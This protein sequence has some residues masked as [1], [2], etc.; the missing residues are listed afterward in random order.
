MRKTKKK[1]RFAFPLLALVVCLVIVTG[2]TFSLFTSETGVNIAV[3]SGTVKMTAIIDNNSLVLSSKGVDRTGENKLTFENGGTAKFETDEE[4]N[5]PVLVLTN[6]T[7]GDSVAF[8][9]D[10]KNES[11]VDLQYRVTWFVESTNPTVVGEETFD[12]YD[13]LVAE[14]DGVAISNGT[15]QWTL[16]QPTSE[17]GKMEKTIKVSITF[18]MG[19][20]AQLEEYKS[21]MGQTVNIGFTVEAVQANGTAEYSETAYV[22]NAT[23]LQDAINA[24]ATKIILNKDIDLANTLEIPASASTFSLKDEFDGVVLDLNGHTI[25]APVDPERA[26]GGHYYAIINYGNLL[27]TGNGTINSRGVENHGSMTIENGTYNNIDTDGGQAIRNIDGFVHIING[28]FSAQ[29]GYAVLT[30]S[31]ADV[32]CG[33]MIIDNATING[34]IYFIGEELVINNADVVNTKSGRHTVYAWGSK[35]TIEDGKF[36]NENTSNATIKADDCIVEINGGKYTIADGNATVGWTSFLIDNLGASHVTVNGGDFNGHIRTNGMT[37]NEGNFNDGY[38]SGYTV[39][40]EVVINGGSFTGANSVNFAKNYLSDDSSL[41]EGE[42]GTFVTIPVAGAVKVANGFYFVEATNTYYI[43]SAE[44][45]YFFANEVNAPEKPEYEGN[46]FA[47]KTVVLLNDVDF[48]GAEWAPIGNFGYSSKQFAG[49]FDGQGHTVSNFKITQ[50]SPDRSGKNRSS[51]GFF[52]NVNGTVKNLIVSKASIIIASD[53]RFTGALIGRLNGGLVENCHVVDSYVNANAWQVGGLVGQASMGTI[54]GC[55]VVNTT[56]M[57]PAGVGAIAGFQQD[58]NVVIIKNCTVDSCAIGQNRSYGSEYYDNMFGTILGHNNSDKATTEIS[59]CTVTNT[60]VFGKPDNTIYGSFEG[61]TMI[62]DGLL[63]RSSGFVIGTVAYETLA[64][65]LNAA[66]EGDVIHVFE[67]VVLA[68]TISIEKSVTID[69]HGFS[70]LPED[71]TK[72]YNSACMLGNSGWVDG[73]GETIKILNAS[74]IGWT[75]NH[76]VIRAQGVT[77]ELDGCTFDGNAVKNDAYG[78]VSFNYS[79]A[80]VTN[81]VFQNNLSKVVDINYN[82]DTSKTT[83]TI[84]NCNFTNNTSAGAGIVFR[85]AGYAIVKNS[86]FVGNTVSTTG[87]AA[88]VYIGFSSGGNEVSGCYFEGNAVITSHATTKRL[89]SAI[90]CDGCVI[91]NNVFADGNTVTRNGV[92]L[93]T[94]VSIASYYTTTDISGNYW[95]GNVPTVGVDYVIEYGYHDTIISSYYT[96]YSVNADGSYTFA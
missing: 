95:N 48:K 15:S 25:N 55:S 69:A 62:V 88:T 63:H 21:Y 64:E 7:P 86:K 84:D 33:T 3:T 22:D 72:T 31:E 41:V 29:G 53:G 71:N 30:T 36:H 5:Y 56:V 9:I 43:D 26:G 44:G 35:I 93:S 50:D 54:S 20:L 80:T 10:L 34:G 13:V 4:T 49:T 17:A 91:N 85:N 52:G 74:F 79:D 89:A 51:Q 32:A 77:V 65:A 37:I 23:G 67:N 75:T 1:S 82:A 38:G 68:E 42:N 90:F 58:N 94:I 83:V 76:G 45:F 39:G 57:A 87:N 24:G 92:A 66:V 14:A 12:L 60:T 59:N 78:V 27:I 81:C 28:N 40:G 19:T 61:S 73:H 47:G 6:I 46:T 18:P 2:S 70:V 11:N 16:W 96:T 8:E